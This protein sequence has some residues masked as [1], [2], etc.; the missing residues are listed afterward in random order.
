MHTPR[1]GFVLQQ[2]SLFSQALGAHASGAALLFSSLNLQHHKSGCPDTK[3]DFFRSL[4]EG[5]ALK[6]VRN[7]FVM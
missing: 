7:S 1:L 6:D 2:I 4:P 3:P 5:H